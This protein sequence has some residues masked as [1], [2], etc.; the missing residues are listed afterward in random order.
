VSQSPRSSK[1][2][3]NGERL[4]CQNGREA[5]IRKAIVMNSAAAMRQAA[6]L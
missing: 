2:G 4:L 5:S 6:T 3:E 1:L